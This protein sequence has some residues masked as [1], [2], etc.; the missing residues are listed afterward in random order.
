[1][2][3]LNMI[4]LT[5]GSPLENIPPELREAKSLKCLTV[6]NNTIKDL[7]EQGQLKKDTDL[8]SA[9]FGNSSFTQDPPPPMSYGWPPA[10]KLSARL[11]FAAQKAAT[12]SRLL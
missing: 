3:F 8:P 11:G 4:C 7:S 5:V 1:M 6:N 9:I 12:D 10:T 2:L